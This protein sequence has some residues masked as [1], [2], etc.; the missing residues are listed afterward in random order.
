MATNDQSK[1]VD[2]YKTKLGYVE[3][4]DWAIPYWASYLEENKHGHYEMFAHVNCGY[5]STPG[6]PPTLEALKR[7]AQSLAHLISTI[8]PS[9]GPGEIDNVNSGASGA[10]EFTQ[11]EAFDWL[12]NLEEAYSSDDPAHHRPLNSL[13]NQARANSDIKGVEFHCPLDVPATQKSVK[14]EDAAKETAYQAERKTR[15]FARHWNLLRHANDCLEILDHEFSA[16]GGLLSILPTEHEVEAE[17][18]D[19]AKNTLIG[20]WL[21][22]TQALTNRMH[23]LEINYSNCLDALK[24]EA[25]IPSQ[26][27]SHE[28]PDGRSGRE[29]VFPQDRWVLANAGDDVQ[30]WVHQILDKIQQAEDHTMV[31]NRAVGI[32]GD[33][34]WDTAT[35]AERGLVSTDLVTRYYRIRGSASDRGPIFVLPGF[36]DRPHVK[37][38]RMMEDRPTVVGLVAPQEPKII[39][40][41]SALHDTYLAKMADLAAKD[42]DDCK[43]VRDE[44]EKLKN[45][46]K[47]QQE[48]VSEEMQKNSS[49]TTAT[50]DDQTK[51]AAELESLKKQLADSQK[52][53]EDRETQRQAAQTLYDDLLSNRYS[54]LPGTTGGAFV[55]P[56]DIDGHPKEQALIALLKS[57]KKSSRDNEVLRDTIETLQGEIRKNTAATKTTAPTS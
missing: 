40:S 53:A 3:A 45:D 55:V 37:Y 57:L 17:Q 34:I 26:H 29:I 35:E 22:F 13:S 4:T 31:A 48:K 1:V 36:A 43:A 38:T 14:A 9:S 11:H 7:H 56:R 30:E 12:N 49:L 33:G 10:R 25:F 24:G 18:L 47:I 50:T 21:T 51:V 54:G 6:R 19:M 41:A 39:P 20:Q 27:L 42:K 5:L 16:T 52:L 23:N 28:G 15:P 46:L 44:N 2:P 8:A 32:V